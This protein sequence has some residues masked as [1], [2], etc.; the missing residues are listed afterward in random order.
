M[1]T[2]SQ[3]WKN[4][5][6]F[7]SQEMQSFCGILSLERKTIFGTLQLLIISKIDRSKRHGYSMVCANY[8]TGLLAAAEYGLKPEMHIYRS[9][10]RTL[11]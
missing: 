4:T 3:L 7:K 9:Q 1:A 5:Q 2:T 8:F 10:D 11:V 6:L